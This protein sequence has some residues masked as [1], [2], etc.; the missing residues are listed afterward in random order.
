MDQGVGRLMARLRETGQEENTLVLFLADNGGCAEKI[1]RG[2]RTAPP[3]GKESFKSYGPPWANA[4][5]TPFRL[6]KHWVHEGGISTP[7][8]AYWPAGIRRRG[9][10]HD[11]GHL[12]DVMATCVDASGAPY[13]KSYLDRE[14]PG[15]EGTSLLPVFAGK[16]LPARA[17]YWEHEGNRAVR[18]GK[19]KLVSRFPDDWELYDLEADRTELHNLAAAQPERVREMA[20]LY[21]AWSRRCGVEPWR[22]G[23]PRKVQVTNSE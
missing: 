20:A 17:L 15:M 8:I 12:I 5:N 21:A 19:W 22:R 14:I 13:P 3:G 7:L 2:D 1:L 11:P 4:S 18:R 9:V 23:G 16:R 10:A 6:Y